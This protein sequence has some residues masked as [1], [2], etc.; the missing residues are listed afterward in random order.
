MNPTQRS[1]FERAV[2]VR[3]CAYAPYSKFHVGVSL[4]TSKGHIFS[5]CNVENAS[6]GLS[7]CAEMSAIAQM[8]AAGE[9]QISGLLVIGGGTA[10]CTPC[11]RC[12]QMIREFAEQNT[13]IYLCSIDGQCETKTLGELLP[14]S[15]GPEC[16]V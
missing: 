16:L 9:K 1:L 6:Y 14:F 2:Q 7:M 12:R 4:I 15:F 8:I 5:G 3:D 13:P 11:G 10:I